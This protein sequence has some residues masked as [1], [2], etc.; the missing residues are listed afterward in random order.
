M[1][2]GVPKGV[3]ADV[4]D[5]AIRSPAWALVATVLVSPKSD[6]FHDALS[7]VHSWRLSLTW[8]PLLCR[9]AGRD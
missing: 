8:P 4:D 9:H 6:P 2:R 3:R 5:T 1:R 7:L